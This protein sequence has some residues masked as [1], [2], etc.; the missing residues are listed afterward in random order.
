MRAQ[1][2]GIAAALAVGIVA[3]DRAM[4]RGETMFFG[5]PV[6]HVHQSPYQRIVITQ[7]KH[8]TRLFLNGQLQFSSDD[9]H[10]YH[11]TLVH[12]AV[13]ALGHVPKHALILGGG[14]GLAA[15]ELLRYP[16]IER[17]T[18]VDLDP[19]VTEVFRN[20]PL[21]A[22]LNGGAL[23]DPRVTV[24]NQ[25]AFTY[26]EAC[27]DAF[28]LAVVDFPDPGN[29]AVGKLY[30]LTFYQRLRERL[31][32]RGVAV[33]QTTSPYYARKSFWMMAETIAAAQF[34]VLPMH[35]HVPS[36]G[37]WGFVLAGPKGMPAPEKLL[38]PAEQLRF[39]G[40]SEL[41]AL[42]RFPRDMARVP[43]GINRLNDQQLVSTYTTE[44]E[45]WQR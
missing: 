8:T 1:C 25:D 40:P 3:F 36:F 30:T 12:P 38:L 43:A 29:Y 6:V 20:V 5:A 34:E 44:W 42:F 45:Q 37:E 18:M 27:T 17:I 11:E 22:K 32:I 15:R 19:A 28:D 21:A 24:V 7:S 23:R 41:G 31:S 26:L 2:I 35:V 13:A 4:V 33:V 16:G 14:D 9:E 10:R 39:L